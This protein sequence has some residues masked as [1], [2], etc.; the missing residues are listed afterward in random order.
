MKAKHK[1]FQSN[2]FPDGQLASLQVTSPGI[3]SFMPHINN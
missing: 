1:P 3:F 2:R